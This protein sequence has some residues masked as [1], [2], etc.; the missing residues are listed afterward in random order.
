MKPFFRIFLGS[1][2]ALLAGVAVHA[3]PVLVPS[4]VTATAASAAP[5]ETITITVLA[6]NAGAATPTDDLGAG[7][8][9]TGTVVFTHRVTGATISTGSVAFRTTAIVA[10][11]GGAG[12]FTRTFSI[13][14]VTSQAGAYDASVTLTAASSGTASGSFTS[15]TVLTV[16]GKPDF[17]FTALTYPAGTAYRGGDVIPMTLSYTNRTSSNGFNNVPYVSSTNGN[18]SYFRIEVI[19][20]SNPTFGDT[21]DFLLTSHD[22]S[23]SSGSPLNAN[24]TSTTISWSQ[25]LP[26]NFAGTYYVMAKIDTNSG[27][28]ETVENDLSDN[29]NNIYYSPDTNGARISLL[30]TNFPTTYWAS[31]SSNAYSDNPSLSADGR[32]TTYASDATTLG[33]GD[34]NSVRDIFLYDNLTAGVRRLSLSQQGAQSNGAS[35]N[36]VLSSNGTYVA[37]SSDATNLALD[38]TNGFSDIYVVNVLTGVITRISLSTAGAA[39]NGSNFKP[40]ISATGRYIAWESNATNLLA[41]GTTVGVTHIYLRDRDVSA[42]GTF[43]TAGNVSTVLVSQATGAATPGDGNS[44]QASISADGQYVAFAS[45]ATNLGGTVGG[46]FRNIYLRDV[47]NSTTTLASIGVAAAASNG[48]SRAPSL[49]RN[50]GVSA[51]LSADGRYIAFGSEASNLIAADTNAVSDIFVFDRVLST[52]TR[53]SVSS[54][55]AEATDPSPAAPDQRLGSINPTISSTGRYVAFASLANNLTPGDAIGRRLTPDEDANS[56]MDVFV[57]DRDVSGSGTYDTAANIATTMVS[58]N[59][60]GYQTLNLLGTASTAASDIYPVISADGRWV[61]FPSDAENTAG[62][63]HG[64]TNRRSPD[65]NTFRDVFLHDR[66]INALPSATTPPSVS[67]TSPVTGTT[68]PVNSALTLVGSASAPAGTIASVQFFVNGTS[69]GTDATFPYNAVW[70]PTA[71]GSFALSALVTDSFGNQ[72]TSANVSITIA[73]V[74]PTSPTVSISSP[75]NGASLFAN[76]A[77]TVSASATDADGTIASVQFF[78]NGVSIGSDNTFPYSIQFTPTATGSYTLTAVATDNGGNQTTTT[79]AGSPSVTVTNLSAPAISITSPTPVQI[80]S[81]TTITATTTTAGSI[82]S[83]QFL[84]NGTALGTVTAAPFTFAW[85]PTAAGTYT[86]SAVATDNLGS[87]TTSATISVVVS[88]GTSPT[89]SLASPAAGTVTVNT[90]QTLVAAAADADG[91]VTSVRFSVNGAALATVTAFPF[92]TTWT[93]T[94]SGNYTLQAVATD[95]L[96]NQ[97]TSAAVAMVVSSG[98]APTVSISSPATGA[99]AATGGTTT[100]TA[101]ATANTGTIANVRFFANGV[102]LG[103]DTTF[104]YATTFSTAANGAY[105]LTAVATDTVGNQTTSAPVTLN[106]AANQSPSATLTAPAAGTVGVG[107]ATTVTATAADTDGTVSSV[108]FF[109]NGVSL[110]TDTTSPYSLTWT[111]TV[112]GSYSLT[113]VATDDLAAT[114]TSAAVA[115]TVTGGNQPTA[116]VT[117]PATGSS[118]AVNSAAT[119]TATAGAVAPLTVASVQFFANGVALGTDTV[120]PYTA[121]WTPTA[122]GTYSLTA[123]VIDSAGNQ[124]TSTGNSITVAANSSP[125]VSVTSPLN[126]ATVGVGSSNTVTAT[127]AD[128]DGT[129]SSVQFFANGVSLATDTT[130][131]Y[132]ATWT[133]TVAGAYAVTAVATDNLGATTTSAT[134]TV[135]V[136]G[137]NAPATAVTAPLTGASLAVNSTAA[138]TAT[139]TAIAPATIASV[140]FFANGVALGTDTAFP[141]T[142]TWTPTANGSYS[143]TSLATDTSGNQATSSAITV[144]VAANASPAVALT[145]PAAG[146]VG[147]GSANPVTA[148][149]TDSD[150]TVASVQ[151]FANGTSLATDPTSPYSTTFTPT[152]AGSYSLTAVATDNLGATTTSAAVALTVTGGNQPSVNLTAPAAAAVLAIG[153]TTTVTATATAVAPATIASVQFL[154]NGVVLA[155]DT[156]FPYSAP[157]APTATGTYSFTALTTDSAGNQSTSAAVAVTVTANTA[158]S[159]G[160]TAPL[161]GATVGVGSVNTVAAAATDTEGTIASVQFF[162]NGSSLGTDTT[163]PYTATFTPTVAGSYSLTAVAT[164]DLGATTTSTVI[165]VTVTG[166]N[167]PSVAIASPAAGAAVAVNSTATLT[168]TATAV[169]GTIASVQFFANNVFLGTDL[170]FPYTATWTPTATGNYSLTA[171]TTDTAGNQATSAAVAI[172]VAANVAPTVSIGSPV[173][174][175]TVPIGTATTISATSAD[176]DGT[177]AGVQFFVNG[178]LIGTDTTAPYSIAWTPT[179]NGSYTLTAVA[180]DNAGATTTSAAIGVTAGGGNAPT[181]S[182]TAPLAGSVAVGSVNSVTALAGATLSGTSIAGVQFFANNTSIGTATTFPHRITWTPTVTGTYALTAVATD[183]AGN[184]ATSASVSIT[185]AA[186]QLPAVAVTA[187]A[188]AASVGV[189]STNAVAATATDADG[190]IVSVQFFATPVGGTAASLGTDLT[191]P[192]AATWTPNVAGTY[193]ITA[194][195]TDNVGGTTTSAAHTVTVTGGLAPAVALVSPGANLANGTVTTLTATASAAT[196]TIA[197]VQFFANGVSLGTDT[198]FPYTA[199]WTPVANGNI[200]LTAV[201]TDTAGNQATSATVTVAVAANVAPTVTVT[202]PANAASVGVGSV[203]AVTATAAD[204]DGTIVSVQ[205]FANGVS[206]AAADTT[207]PFSASWTPTV[208]GSYAITAVAI[209]NLGATTTSAANT[210]TVTGGAAPVVAVVSPG[211]AVAVNSTVAIG[212]TATATAPATIARIEFFANGVSLGLDTTFPY[213]ATWTPTATGTYSLTAVALDTAGNQATSSAVSVTVAANQ[214]P[215]VSLT[216][217]ANAATVGVGSVNPVAATAADTDGS[218]GSVQFFAN[219]VSLGTDTTSPYTASWTPTVAGTYALTAV[220][221]DNVGGTTT[222][223]TNT[224]TVSGG[225]APTVSV[226]APANGS[227][228]AVNTTSTVTATA[229]ATLAGAT[230][231]RVELFANGVSLGVDTTFPYSTTWTPAALGTYALTALATDTS[232]NQAT[233]TANSVTVSAAGAGPAP[234]VALTSPNSG[235]TYVVGQPVTMG[236][237]VG[238]G[239]SFITAVQFFVNGIS[240]GGGSTPPNGQGAVPFWTAA[241]TPAAPGSYTFTAVVTDATGAQVTSAPISITVSAVSVPTIAI[242]SPSNATSLAPNLPQTL[243]ATVG[244]TN[245]SV[246]NVQFFANNVSLGS[247]TTFPY[248]VNWTPAT[249]GDYSVIAVVTTSVGTAVTSGPRIYSVASGTVPTVSVTS[250]AS[251]NVGFPQNIVATAAATQAGA[252]LRDVQFFVN[253]V[254]IGTDATFPF[255]L[256]WTPIVPGAYSLTAVATD[257]LGNRQTS[258]AVAVTANAVSATA[259]SVN[260]VTPT[261]LSTVSIG[262]SPAPVVTITASASDPDGTIASVQF[263]ANGVSLGTVTAFPY[264]LAWTPTAEG[265]YSL[266]A[267]AIDNGGNS[268]RSSAISVTATAAGAPT[269]NLTTSAAGGTSTVN[270]PVTLNANA[271][272]AFGRTVASVQFL[273]NGVNVGAADTTFPY[274]TT[275]TPTAPG[276]YAITATATDDIAVS[277]TSS[278]VNITITAGTPPAVN[279]TSPGNGS[280]IAVST[281]QTITANATASA[282]ATIASVQFLVNG[283]SIGTDNS[284]PYS[285]SY[286]PLSLGAYTLTAIATDSLGNTTT[287]TAVN[288]TVVAA[289]G[290]TT[291]VTAPVNG[292][293]GNVG[294]PVTVTANPTSGGAITSVQFFANGVSI[295]TDTTA[296]YSVSWIPLV[297]GPVSL[298]AVATDGSNVTGALSNPVTFTVLTPPATVSITGPGA[299]A[300]LPVNVAQTVFASATVTNGT[301]VSVQFFVNG[302]ALATDTTFPFSAP[303]TPVTTGTFALTAKATDNFGTVTDS[304]T[305]SGVVTVTVTGGT[306]PGVAI[307]SPANPSTIGVGL[308]QT[309]VANATAV[310]GTIAS[311]QFR[312]NNVPLG[313]DTTFPY[314]QAWTPTAVGTYEITAVATD[315]LGNQTT[316]GITTI[317]VDPISAGAPVVSLTSPAA[318]AALPVGVTTL[319]TAAATDPDGTITSVEFISNGAS[320]GLDTVFPYNLPFTPGATGT[321]VLSVRAT[322]NGG[323][324]TTSTA[325]TVTVTGGTAPSVAIDGPANGVTLGVNVPQ[326]ITATATSPTGF[327]KD[328]Q[329]FLNG[330]PLSSDSNYPYVADWNPTAIGTYTLT[331]RATDNLGNI[332]DS[333]PVVVV[334]GASAAPTVSVTNPPDGSSYTVGAVLNLTADAADSDGTISG[335]QFFVNG[336]PQG[337]ADTVSPYTGTWSPGSVGIY[338]LT[339]RATDNNGNLTTSAPVTVTIGANAAPTVAL[340]SPAAG[341]YSLGNLVLVSAS[342]NDADGSVASVQF[343]ANGLAIGT[344]TGAP[345]NTSWRPTLAGT[346]RL[347]AVATDNVGNVTTSAVVSV[348]ITSTAAPAVTINN[349][350]VGQPYGVGNAIP[351]TANPS[352]GNGPIAQMQFFVNGTSIGVDNTS[353]YSSTFTPNAPGTYTLLAIATDSAGL[354]SSSSAAINIVVTGNSAPAVVLTSPPNGT[355]VNGGTIVNLTAIATDVDGTIASVRFLANGNQVG[356]PATTVPFGTAWIPSAAGTYSVTA[357]AT[358]NSG[359]VTNSASINV[360]VVANA[361]PTVSLTSPGNGATVRVGSGAT[362]AATASDP[363]GTIASIQ[364]FANGLAIGTDNTSPYTTQWTP[365][366][367]GIYRL[368]AVA[369]DNSGAAT[370]SGTVLVLAVSAASGGTDTVYAGSYAGSGEIG[371]FAV[372]NIRGK[373][374]AFIGFSQT[375]PNKV[376]FFDSLPVDLGGSFFLGDSLGRAVISGSVNDTGV[377]GSLDAGRV[378]FIAPLTFPS[379]VGTVAS[380]LYT[381]NLTNRAGSVLS[382]IVGSDGSIFLYAT[383]G[384]SFR[385]AGAGS[386][387]ATGSFAITTSSG[388]RFTGR[389]D[390]A[391]GFL[392]GTLT[393][394]PGGTF[395]AAIASGVSFSDGFLRNLSTRGPVGTGGDILVAGFAVSGNAPKKVLVRAIGPTLAAFGVEGTLADT[396]LDLFSGNTLVVANDNWGGAGD[397]IAASAAVGAFPLS[398]SSLDSVVLATLPPGLYTAQVSGVG[399]RTGVALVELYDVDTLQ[400]FSTQKLTNVA[401]RAV[402]TAAQN[403]IIAGFMVSGTTAKKVL[404]RAVGPTLGRAPFNIPGTLADPMLSLVRGDGVVVRENDNWETGNDASLI[405]EASVKVGAFALSAGAKD[406]AILINL[407]PGTYNAQ[408]SGGAPGTGTVLVEVY[409][410]P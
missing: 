343:F 289:V 172:T 197:S 174:A 279:L 300:S 97:T 347:T 111:P 221:I 346:F 190:T 183:T 36:P 55:G 336:V 318:G 389:A 24:N 46:G 39:A 402:L 112:A 170:V 167:A 297:G 26:G 110:G 38:D 324:I 96:G 140:Q 363:D 75:A 319:L 34:T 310:N 50:P 3:A 390:P 188:D 395:T 83:V 253:G 150:G 119:V 61:A 35:N 45:D 143:L 15:T 86:L 334:L 101:T 262:T 388:N 337:A 106:V 200:A 173:N 360:T 261:N 283:I 177:I 171:L 228:V 256:A 141:Y 398:P 316:S 304:A 162:A 13:P 383:D 206:L 212:A 91:N 89:V 80:N 77:T 394:G 136:T 137:G 21:D 10:G 257:T 248:S 79:G 287:S 6:T 375:T 269:V 145:A 273:A 169:T 317:T 148:T 31:T 126:A 301:V 266:T 70:T 17:D 229:S 354:S 323:N 246:L 207:S 218:V 281:A 312:A 186:N 369:L 268:T 295:G 196:G 260:I 401:T 22:V 355:N 144:T 166:G 23:A 308:A 199:T 351:F 309:L 311:V 250:P 348:T 11:A 285:V 78:A 403:Q 340:T 240:I 84:A 241:W 40:A 406:S 392:S 353:P 127:A 116:S 314:N 58:K 362:L 371:R 185:V 232:G 180:T 1:V 168:A 123:L 204:T 16:T 239:S 7:G 160:I 157:F 233:S 134:N 42:S 85:T 130:S 223:A 298:T 71:V 276:V 286:T 377:S 198:T 222:S 374:A 405:S 278:A 192:Y 381:G 99:A 288:F 56:A 41:A 379:T 211:A 376:Y 322:D 331:A 272:A 48:S 69:L 165:S 384:G 254:S 242:A 193:A 391:T 201:A 230:I 292:T 73:A 217:P 195:A 163:A 249:T 252:V 29:G 345:Y 81:A 271:T 227:A 105:A 330:Q 333:A 306:A 115:M 121:A 60:F 216:A 270:S 155:T 373:S 305:T 274:S 205:F 20:S 64:A 357:Q 282:P 147:V 386:V 33:T 178:G 225:N 128:T 4:G 107:A 243:V 32:Y 235:A 184:Q 361:V 62:L 397:V 132:T 238:L 258:A 349:P 321:Y 372:I 280:T 244:V 8:T 30:P 251:V 63:V 320:L 370:T 194:V 359:N 380:G 408:V 329:F 326:T 135:T 259:P 92:T 133:P 350:I 94:V 313:T 161:T 82:A 293:S 307:S 231:A 72:A 277:G 37:F 93:P 65:L 263:F 52:I 393:G 291:V 382:A 387:S 49:N 236:A 47:T 358:D 399:G 409:E 264:T 154:A 245:A 66:R 203:N 53:V 102:L 210:V 247:V 176:T 224:V 187:P 159:V 44:I 74:S 255:G 290:P 129:V 76:G 368:N 407:P 131:P 149:A 267:L 103:T 404:I 208:A 9:V 12:T 182:L 118:L 142:A 325:V 120:F 138:L 179:I 338:T 19:L 156:T 164:D 14:T 117:A 87:Q 28:D 51:G 315:T 108:Q 139:A 209:D 296:P 215:T 122:T 109:A 2:L 220:A 385:D 59:R 175:A 302:V 344:A 237:T 54:A 113:A 332:T 219:G 191:S 158:P 342:A 335:V 125:S 181:V 124:A 146:T 27:I 214:L 352:G 410:V 151:F 356:V 378:S 303:W 100:L 95:N 234:T 275:W 88:A 341:T 57:M 365:G 68:Y 90:A 43:D 284:S 366:A 364:F 213:T 98:T 299:G 294:S 67:I 189:G 265:V 226:T 202:A 152:V 5:G 328:V 18:A 396:R 104:P 400:A 327:I 25:I 114:G 153:S 367:E 339:A